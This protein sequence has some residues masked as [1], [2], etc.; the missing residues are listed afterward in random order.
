[1]DIQITYNYFPL[2]NGP[3]KLEINNAHQKAKAK[4]KY[5]LKSTK[6]RHLGA[7]V[8]LVSNS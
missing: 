2:H 7:S 3:G 6:M 4:I 1:M 5:Y 8:C